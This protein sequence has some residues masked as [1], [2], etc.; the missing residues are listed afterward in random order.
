MMKLENSPIYYKVSRCG[1]EK[2]WVCLLH[3]AYVDHGMFREQMAYFKD[4]VNLLLVDIIGHGKSVDA[5]KGD[6]MDKMAGWIRDILDAEKVEKIHLVGISLGAVLVQ[7]FANQYPSRVASLACFGGYDINNFD[8]TMQKG[9]T[10][11]QMGMMLKALVSIRWFAEA[12]KKI[13][14]YTQQAQNDFYEMNLRFPKKSFMYLAG[15]NGLVNK[16]PPA[17]RPYPLLIGCGEHDI[18]MEHKAVELWGANEP[19]C[20]V[21]VFKGAGHCANMDVP[22]QFNKVMEDFWTENPSV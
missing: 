5:Q 2:P 9:N 7:D 22:Q 6:G 4:R 3:A 19:T 12:N 11:A 13:S 1:S 10:A 21:V 14:A 18:P 20:Q 17:T 8:V 15:L 16:Y